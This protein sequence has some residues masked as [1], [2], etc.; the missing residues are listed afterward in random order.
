MIGPLRVFIV[1]VLSLSA[2]AADKWLRVKSENFEIL[3]TAGDRRAK[4][5]LTDFERVYNF[6]EQSVQRSIKPDVPMRIIHFRNEKEYIPYRPSEVAAA[7]YMPGPDADYVVMHGSGDSR[8]A[9]HE[10]VHLLVKHSYK[11]ALP[12]WLN[13][14][15]AELY[16]TMRQIGDKVQV[17]GLIDGHMHL[18]QSQK[19]VPLVDLL[20]AGHD[21][22]LYNRK[23][24]A[25]MF[26]AES[27]ALTHMLQLSPEYRRGFNKFFQQIAVGTPSYQALEA[28]YSK[29]VARIEKDLNAYLRGNSFFGVNFDI[30]MRNRIAGDVAVDEPSQGAIDAALASLLAGSGHRAEAASLIASAAQRDP[31]DPAIAIARGYLEWRDGKFEEARG[32]FRRALELGSENKRVVADLA[33]LSAG[34]DPDTTIAALTRLRKIEPP[35]VEQKILMA[36]QLVRKKLYGAAHGELTGIKSVTADQAFRLM[37]V[38]ARSYDGLNMQDEALAAAQEARKHAKDSESVFADQMV[39]YLEFRKQRAAVE[40]AAPPSAENAVAVTPSFEEEREGPV[41]RRRYVDKNG[42]KIEEIIDRSKRSPYGQ[43]LR[44]V[45]GKFTMFDCKGSL[46]LVVLTLADGSTAAYRISEP[47]NLVAA[48]RGQGMEMD[49]TCGPQPLK[50]VSV[51]YEPSTADGVAG[52]LWQ[53]H[54]E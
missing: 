15:V 29:P 4:E 9:I 17:G 23:Q 41:M 22:K 27:W 34:R 52:I 38:R 11:T 30:R 1:A 13:E 44:E 28:V 2:S 5:V 37:T 12:V 21:S 31:K 50:P 14:G 51:W 10:F 49:L 20:D 19:P 36:E 18:F 46:P 26:Y 54:F 42:R 53:I 8:I 25:G 3:S 16:S 35:S 47:N 7:F 32:E 39:R 40:A 6:F 45:K 48:N 24:H 33:R 43:L